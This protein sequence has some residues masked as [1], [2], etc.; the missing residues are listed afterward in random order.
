MISSSKRKRDIAMKISHT[1]IISVALAAILVAI[2]VAFVPQDQAEAAPLS[3]ST[4]GISSVPCVTDVEHLSGDRYLIEITVAGHTM[5]KQPVVKKVNR[6][7]KLRV[8]QV[9]QN[10][11]SV[12]IKRG[13]RYVISFNGKAIEYKL[14]AV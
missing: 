9:D 2:C 7:N 6:T 5:G 8:Y 10:T 13:T 12:E 11:W 4:Y 1:L 3:A 14:K